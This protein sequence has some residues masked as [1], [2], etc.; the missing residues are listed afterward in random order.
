[1][2][3]PDKYKKELSHYLNNADNILLICHV[4]PDGDSVGSML[5]L[6]HFLT[7]KGKSV[8]MISPN[9]L[10]E[11]L[12]WMYGIEKI[13]IFIKN[14][15]KCFNLIEKADLI[16][17]LDF[18]H[19]NR[20]GEVEKNVLKSKA[21]KIMID[22]HLNSDSFCDLLISDNTRSSTAEILHEIICSINNGVFRDK[23]YSEAIYV[24]II[25]DTGN[26]EHGFF[27]GT[28]FRH[29]AD[30]FDAGIDKDKI[31]NLVF[32]NF[33]ES[34]IKLLGYA[35]YEKM[36]I[37]PE[38]HTAYI[39]LSKYDLRRFNYQKGDTEGFV[40][41]PLSVKGIDFSALLIEKEGFVKLSFRSRGDFSVSSFAEKYFQG[42]GHYNAA[43]GDYYD[44]LENTLNY[45]LDMLKKVRGGEI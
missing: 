14:R 23:N 42:G 6:Y 8:E 16:I 18:N 7:S 2:L 38:Y 27:S 4:N 24:G 9:Y 28:T 12:T 29:I 17:M 31:Y 43:G 10:Q 13:N 40:N 25:T 34:R 19:S 26:F 37:I 20:L 22:H 45:F 39:C 35:L 15:K 41:L 33:S 21:K 11:F 5:A 3:E 1:M 44:T 30:I 32:N 36:V